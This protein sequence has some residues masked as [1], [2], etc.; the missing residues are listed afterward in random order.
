MIAYFKITARDDYGATDLSIGLRVDDEDDAANKKRSL[1]DRLVGFAKSLTYTIDGVDTC[2]YGGVDC[3]ATATSHSANTL[4]YMVF[5]GNFKKD[6]PNH[7]KEVVSV[8]E[9]K[10]KYF[11]VEVDGQRTDG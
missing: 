7:R 3:S 8:A 6:H 1:I 4:V 9:A 10:G 2:L 11:I 5:M